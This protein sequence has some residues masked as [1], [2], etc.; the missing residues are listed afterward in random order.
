M[1]RIVLVGILIALAV[2]MTGCA[3]YDTPEFV[4]ISPSQTAFLIPLE[5]ETSVQKGFDSEEFL[6]KHLVATKRVQIPHRWVKKGHWYTN[7]EYI[8]TMRLIL[9]ERKPETREWTAAENTGTSN[10]NQGIEAESKEATG[11]AA[12]MNC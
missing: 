10:A 9:V 8:D 12:S 3:A 6:R 1:K 4:E 5:G 2:S 11:F 7:G